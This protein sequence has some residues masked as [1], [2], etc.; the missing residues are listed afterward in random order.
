MI[1]DLKDN[2]VVITSSPSELDP[3]QVS[4]ISFWGFAKDEE[5]GAYVLSTERPDAVIAKLVDYLA[6][7]GVSY[8]LSSSCQKIF[9]RVTHQKNQFARL[10][11]RA[12]KFKE[13]TFSRHSFG[14]FSSFVK[15]SIPRELRPHQLKAAY[16]LYLLGNGANFSVPG[17]GKTAVVLTVYEKLKQEGKVNLL[18]VVGP[19]ACFGPWKIEFRETLG[20]K[21]KYKILAGGDK[22]LRKSEYSKTASEAAELY[23]TTFHTLLNDKEEVSIFLNRQGA[24]S[25]LVVDEAH[26]IKQV[27]GNWANSV[28]DIAKYARFRVVLT[29]TPMP[30]SYSDVFNLFDFLWPESE[31]IDTETK[32]RIEIQEQKGDKQTPK[33]LLKQHIGPLFYRVR[34]SDLGLT[35]PMFHPPHVM[36]MNKYER[37]L[38]DAIETKIRD[39]SKKDYLRNIDLV[40]RLSRGRIIRLRQCSSYAKLLSSALQDYDEDLIDDEPALRR[41]ILEYDTL[42]QPAKLE[43]LGSLIAHFQREREKAVIWANFIGTLELISNHLGNRGFYNKLIYGKTPIEQ[44]S[45]EEERTR[46]SIR[47]EFV[48]P[49]SGLDILIANPAAC[50]ESISLHKTCHHA[51]YYDLSYNCAQFLQSLDRIH[52]VGG[53]ETS[54]A[55]YHF[56][57]Y[58]N[59]IDQDI[60][61][62]L[63]EKAAR[64]YGIIEEEYC[65]YSLNMFEEENEEIQAYERL[66]GRH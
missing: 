66:F 45:V 23:L 6:D 30:N 65:I 31:P 19:A 60:R 4:Q 27:Q 22:I 52:R 33:N 59:T 58:A 53:S 15:H 5:W 35:A 18:F 49:A 16:H 51:V 2:V 28:L 8:S 54:T 29:G 48:D 34:K 62:N 50:A 47:D 56:L 36:P 55:N 39:Y 12:G 38:Y 17:S 41:I 37:L 13:G 63:D 1:V 11:A 64:M 61:R 57:Q 46:E 42:E 14:E 44:T 25:F 20:R 7:E 9:S 26:Y 32:I 10:K 24:K 43:Y 40:K 21:A 3:Y